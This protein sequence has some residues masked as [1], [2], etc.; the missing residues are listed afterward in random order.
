MVKKLKMTTGN[1]KTFED[2]FEDFLL[3]C[4]ARNLRQG[5]IKHYQDSI[6]QIWKYIPK[7][8][9][10]AEINEDTF[11]GYKIVLRANPA[12]NDVSMYTYSRDLKTILRFFMKEGWLDKMDLQLSKVDKSPTETYT[13]D[14]LIKLM[15][16][17][18]LQKCSFTEYKS[19]V[20]VNFLLSTGMRQNSLVNI[21]IKDLDFDSNV[22]YVMVTKNRKPLV[23]PL[24]SDI[25][26]ILKEYLK[27]RKA[28][29]DEEYL[30]CNEYGYK[31]AKS[32]LYHS[33]Y[34]YNKRRG[35]D[36]TGIHRFRHT[37]AK[38]W[39]LMGGNVVSLQKILGHS[40]LEI[41]QN[42][43]NLLVSDVSRDIEEFNILREFKSQ[44]IKMEKSKNFK[45]R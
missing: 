3:N 10:I 12:I 5:T 16:K 11:D 42:Y 17:P 14:E 38:K 29:D 39:V 32:T 21:R 1:T 28:E 45:R 36:K 26:K 30:F 2:G 27:F 35:V 4:E 7:E 15:K 44:S 9:L 24:N 22:V 41:T 6:K 43:L 25:V 20:I 13:D 8:M 23:I 18:N 31:L 19:W 40:S 37:F 33:L 34:D